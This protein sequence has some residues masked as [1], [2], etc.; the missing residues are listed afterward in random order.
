MKRTLI[1]LLSL[2]VGSSVYA[3]TATNTA[4][5]SVVIMNS[6][7]HRHCCGCAATK[8][9]RCLKYGGGK[10]C[11]KYQSV[12]YNRCIQYKGGKACE[13]LNVTNCK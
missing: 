7:R 13:K 4:L 12:R 2:L 9:E 3:S 11:N 8:Y 1:V 6:S 5:M 10:A